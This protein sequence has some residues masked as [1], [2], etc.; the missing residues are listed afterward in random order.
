MDITTYASSRL[1]YYHD[2]AMGIHKRATA[3]TKLFK[4]PIQEVNWAISMQVPEGLNVLLAEIERDM[5][6]FDEALG[7]L[8]VAAEL[9]EAAQDIEREVVDGMAAEMA[10]VAAVKEAE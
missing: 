8:R 4:R 3:T 5:I 7:R 9:R 2:L 6:R 1:E 10:R